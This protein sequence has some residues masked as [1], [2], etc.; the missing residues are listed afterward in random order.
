MNLDI[1]SDETAAVTKQHLERKVL[2]WHEGYL[3][4]R[5]LVKERVITRRGQ[6]GNIGETGG[7]G[8]GEGLEIITEGGQTVKLLSKCCMGRKK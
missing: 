3:V 7:V 6:E 2:A 8:T 5:H 1:T 4:C